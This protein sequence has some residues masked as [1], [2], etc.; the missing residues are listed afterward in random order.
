MRNTALPLLLLAL[1]ASACGTSEAETPNG[2]VVIAAADTDAPPPRRVWAAAGDYANP[3]PDGRLVTFVDWSTGDV[4]V[5]DIGTAESRR[6]TDK[7]AWTQ[8]GSWAEYPVFSP[9]GSRVVYSYGNVLTGSPFRYE[10]RYVEL[11]DTTQHLLRSIGDR[12]DWIAPLDW[13]ERGILFT[14][15]TTPEL[16]TLAI[17]DPDTRDVTVLEPEFGRGRGE[18]REGRFS[19]D[20]RYVA[21]WMSGL[22]V[23]DLDGGTV[24]QISAPNT[25]LIDWTAAGNGLVVH[26]AHD[27]RTG[28]WLIPIDQGR[29]SGDVRL[30]QDG[31]PSVIQG[32]GRAGEAFYY[33]IP[34]DAPRVHLASVDAAGARI[35][36]APTALTS[37][38]DGNARYP[39]WSPDGNQ[40]AYLLRPL[41]NQ[42]PTR[43]MVRQVTGDG[44]RELA[45][46]DAPHIQ[47]MDWTP[48]GGQLALWDRAGTVHSVSVESGAVRVVL[49]DAG[50]VAALSPDGRT[51]ATAQPDGSA[52][53]E[54]G[55]VM[56]DLADGTRRALEG[57]T[58]E[59][60]RALSFSPDG[61][62]LAYVTRAEGEGP[63]EIRMLPAAGGASRTVVSVAYPRHLE[64]QRGPLV[65]TPDGRHLLVMGGAWEGQ[66]TH[67]LWAVTVAT[68]DIQPMGFQDFSGGAGYASLDPRG[69]RLAYISGDLRKELWV[70]DRIE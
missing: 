34:V 33:T 63:S 18:G 47:G 17:L 70:L 12:D 15:Y 29:Q 59:G 32:G 2:Q 67:D 27:G 37:P 60:V 24:T 51:L 53:S 21:Y 26:G 56:I 13:S 49:S 57:T 4:A 50:Q 36:S 14:H 3:S 38:M 46:L 44:V 58:Q 7:G 55:I 64:P 65:W 25:S 1:A 68:G 28:L 35:L 42:G 11:G 48:D 40:L 22:K 9:D 19:P 31:V 54:R 20:G 16:S 52:S 62:S 23:R 10:L 6:I 41:N 45:R 30:V 39:V 8:N 66:D 61:Q 5:H 43:V 69:T